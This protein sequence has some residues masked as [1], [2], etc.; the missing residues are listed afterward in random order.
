MTLSASALAQTPPASVRDKVLGA[1]GFVKSGA[2][3]RNE[4]GNGAHPKVARARL[5]AARTEYM[6]VT[7]TD[8]PCYGQAETRNFVLRREPDGEWKMLIELP[9]ELM[10]GRSTHGYRELITGGPG[11][12]GNEVYR[13]KGQGY[14]Y[15]CNALPDDLVNADE[16]RA[17]C[18]ERNSQIKWCK[19]GK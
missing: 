17:M 1:A 10:I 3:W 15:A 16:G 19:P 14:A 9:G 6:I 13:W 7:D 12:C 2:A 8:A 5:D 18:R 11:Y 4:C